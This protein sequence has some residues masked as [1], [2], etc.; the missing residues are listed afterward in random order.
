M[1]FFYFDNQGCPI[2]AHRAEFDDGTP[3]FIYNGGCTIK[4]RD[5]QPSL[6]ETFE[7]AST[8]SALIRCLREPEAIDVTAPWM[9]C[10]CPDPIFGPWYHSEESVSCVTRFGKVEI[11]A[12]VR[13]SV[14][15]DVRLVEKFM[16]II[17][18]GV[19]TL[20]Q[21]TLI[22]LT[23]SP[24]TTFKLAGR[25]SSGVATSYIIRDFQEAIGGLDNFQEAQAT[26]VFNFRNRGL[27]I[28]LEKDWPFT[29]FPCYVRNEI[30]FYI[31]YSPMLFSDPRFARLNP[32]ILFG[33]AALRRQ[34]GSE[35]SLADTVQE[36]MDLRRYDAQLQEVIQVTYSEDR[37]RRAASLSWTQQKE[38]W[39]INY[40]L[41]DYE[42]WVPR[43]INKDQTEVLF[44]VYDFVV[45]P[46]ADQKIKRV[47]FLGFRPIAFDKWNQRHLDV[48]EEKLH[49]HKMLTDSGDSQW[50][51]DMR[52]I[53]AYASAP[54]PGQRIDPGYGKVFQPAD[55]MVQKKWGIAHLFHW[56]E[57]DS[58][59]LILD[60]VVQSLILQDTERPCEW[61][62]QDTP[63]QCASP[64]QAL[65]HLP[66]SP[67]LT[68]DEEE[69]EF[70]SDPA[71]KGLLAPALLHRVQVDEPLGTRVGEQPL[72]EVVRDIPSFQSYTPTFPFEDYTEHLPLQET[73]N[74]VYWQDRPTY[75]LVCSYST[76]VGLTPSD[77]SL[78]SSF[79][80]PN[81]DSDELKEAYL[82]APP[83]SIAMFKAMYYVYPGYR[84][85][86]RV[87]RHGITAH[88]DFSLAWDGDY[89]RRKQKLVIADA[90]SQ[91]MTLGQDLQGSSVNGFTE[92]PITYGVGGME[93]VANWSR[94]LSD[95]MGRLHARSLSSE[96]GVE[97]WIVARFGH[98][99]FLSDYI[100]EGPSR[101]LTGHFKGD[102]KTLTAANGDWIQRERLSEAERAVIRGHAERGGGYT[103]AVSLF[104]PTHLIQQQ[105]SWFRAGLWNSSVERLLEFI[106]IRIERE[107]RAYINGRTHGQ[108]KDWLRSTSKMQVYHRSY[109]ATRE[110]LEWGQ[111]LIQS[112]Y[113]QDWNG[114]KIASMEF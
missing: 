23:L 4:Q 6:R 60:E 102:A 8:Q 55:S 27:I 87:L 81:F 47:T 98:R 52:E 71:A 72:I 80:L 59:D 108:W 56:Q 24:P 74:S 63:S 93:Y 40:Y 79:S 20:G 22:W 104:P 45:A 48:L 54:L 25:T 2:V 3:Y 110:D 12:D 46:Q 90:A 64:D 5:C 36:E 88:L 86:G 1:D 39:R 58:E 78:Y 82:L 35:V 28:D 9:M 51:D 70:D 109:N 103:G 16:T 114:V 92:P 19:H 7:D 10:L 67:L 34:R 13:A 69:S 32:E 75:N 100:V 95:N 105:C 83:L 73:V 61:V 50:V 14:M 111:N 44:Q 33:F 85:L 113:P 42:R 68:S 66:D 107:E 89:L 30:P 53:L 65:A 106:A 76:A 99:K 62:D 77:D 31:L 112:M 43:P 21:R 96:D 97:K 91:G 26:G 94:R 29:N 38:G 49:Q 18:N 84:D 15:R 17:Q 41:V 37:V 57:P 101:S 11:P